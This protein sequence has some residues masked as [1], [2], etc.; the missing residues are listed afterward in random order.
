MKVTSLILTGKLTARLQRHVDVYNLTIVVYCFIANMLEVELKTFQSLSYQTS[1]MSSSCRC[2]C[3]Q[4]QQNAVSTMSRVAGEVVTF[5]VV[6]HIVS[7][8]ADS[9]LSTIT[10]DEYALLSW[11]EGELYNKSV[12]DA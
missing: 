5:V 8:L 10:R 2:L 12:I 1:S 9:S 6:S 7:V 11:P 3:V 4:A